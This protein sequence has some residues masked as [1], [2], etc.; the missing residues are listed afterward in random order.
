M[1]CNAIAQLRRDRQ[2]RSEGEIAQARKTRKKSKIGLL[3]WSGDKC[4]L[5]RNCVGLRAGHGPNFGWKS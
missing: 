3:I 5:L 1:S 2:K 4:D